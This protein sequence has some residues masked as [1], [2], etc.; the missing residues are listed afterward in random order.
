MEETKATAQ[1]KV[2]KELAKPAKVQK[3]LA[4]KIASVAKVLAKEPTSVVPVLATMMG[5]RPKTILCLRCIFHTWVAP[6][7]ENSS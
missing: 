1:P 7:L 6:L 3:V 2:P 5:T 4:K